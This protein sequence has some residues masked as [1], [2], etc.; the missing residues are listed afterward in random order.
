MRMKINQIAL[1]IGI[2]VVGL[3]VLGTIGFNLI[4][5]SYRSLWFSQSQAVTL[6]L[7]GSITRHKDKLL[8]LQEVMN[9]YLKFEKREIKLPKPG[10]GSDKYTIYRFPKDHN[11]IVLSNHT[12]TDEE[13][14]SCRLIAEGIYPYISH[15]SKEFGEV[16]RFYI[17]LNSGQIMEYFYGQQTSDSTILRNILHSTQALRPIQGKIGQVEDT[18]SFIGPI[19]QKQLV[20]F[21]T[22]LVFNGTIIGEICLDMN[23]NYFN[24]ILQVDMHNTRVV[25]FESSGVVLS[26]NI[27]EFN[28]DKQLIN[29]FR[30]RPA[31][32]ELM[33]EKMN[34]Y[35][36]VEKQETRKTYVYLYSLDPNTWIAL[37]V[38]KATIHKQIM[39]TLFPFL[40]AFVALWAA[41]WAFYKQRIITLQLK[42]TSLEL[43]KARAEAELANHAKS[44]FLANMSHEIRTPMNAIIGFSQI[45]GK[46]IKDPVEANYL[47]SINTSGKTLLSLIN[48]ILDLSKIEAGKLEIHPDPFS[49]RTLL[50]EIESLF[51][52][53]ME[54]KDLLFI[55]TVD[56]E[57][58]DQL[59]GDELRIRQI[60]L[61]FISNAI[62]F[63]DEGSV[64]VR[65]VMLSR[66]KETVDMKLIVSDTGI[67]IAK[68]Q[69][70]KIFGSFTQVENQD[71]RKYGGTGLG[72]AITERLVALMGGEILVE[73]E[74]FQGSSFGVVLPGM[75][76]FEGNLTTKSPEWERL[77]QIRF[78]QAKVIVVD[79]VAENRTVL[80]AMAADYGVTIVSASNGKEALEVIAREKPILALMDLRMPVM[81]GFAATKAIRANPTTATMPVIAVSASAFHQHEKDVF[82]KGF[83]GF[84]RKPVILHELLHELS[85][86]LPHTFLEKPT[87]DPTTVEQTS[88][89]GLDTENMGSLVKE[90]NDAIIPLCQEA[91]RKQSIQL[92]RQLLEKSGTLADEYPWK[93][94]KMALVELK[95]A[96]DAFDIGLIDKALRHFETVVQGA[97]LRHNDQPK[98]DN[99]A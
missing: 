15:L 14:A 10:K 22:G 31:F 3:L 37:Y 59:V 88:P 34:R 87:S 52:A 4:L 45:L 9:S 57:L 26:S 30:V 71:S 77:E 76:V 67:G 38:E 8:I 55:I 70:A 36:M 16:T 61:N 20:T 75:V 84:L 74:P 2:L 53:R 51:K 93:P 80:S 64:E 60:L 11:L 50:A 92:S 43:E 32:R 40:L 48:D 18:P 23:P 28:S 42:K 33:G 85:L 73:S 41:S 1:W 56:E 44:T 12:L 66:S 82:E 62:K 97:S 78:D 58:P 95:T 90:L 89:A 54:E 49:I 27:S 99:H 29:I 81:D 69:V 96:I 6:K 98:T 68:D 24:S 65:A 21:Y 17:R 79:D 47:R 46:M 72:L 7:A 91:I 5:K 63:T 19:S 25:M 86:F 39:L 83:N 13:L 94:L 35:R